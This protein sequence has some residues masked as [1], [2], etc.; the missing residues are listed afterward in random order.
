M[1]P[2]VVSLKTADRPHRITIWLGLLSPFL[3]LV[4][5]G[6]SFYVFKDSQ[7]SMRVA[8][9][10]YLGFHFVSGDVEPKQDGG[11]KPF[12][13]AASVT[14]KDLGKTPA[15]IETVKKELYAIDADNVWDHIGGESE[16]SPNFDP[17]GPDE[18]LLIEYAAN[19]SQQNLTGDR[20][21]V[22]KIEIHWHDAFNEAQ[23]PEV[24]CGILRDVSLP[25]DGKRKLSAEPCMKGMTFGFVH[26]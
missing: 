11:Q 23:P 24:Y 26:E 9:R 2:P 5:L 14:V 18:P 25:I 15:Y 12:Q 22:Y 3:A 13:V 8:Q 6:V 7:R 16:E 1:E 20:S 19:F 17:I 10:A 4:S 21:V